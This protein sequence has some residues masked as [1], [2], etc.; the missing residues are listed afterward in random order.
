MNLQSLDRIKYFI[1]NRFTLKTI[2][3]ENTINQYFYFD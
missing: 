3:F 2:S 1:F